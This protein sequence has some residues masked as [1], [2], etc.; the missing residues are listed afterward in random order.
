MGHSKVVARWPVVLI[1]TSVGS[2]VSDMGCRLAAMIAG[3][4][5]GTKCGWQRARGLERCSSIMSID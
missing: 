5:G 3:M 2:A 1:C 4:D